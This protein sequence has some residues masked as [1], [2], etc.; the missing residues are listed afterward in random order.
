MAVSETFAD[1]EIQAYVS[2]YRLSRNGDWILD[3]I[4]YIRLTNQEGDSI[5]LSLD[6]ALQLKIKT[7]GHKEPLPLAKLLELRAW[8]LLE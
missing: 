4:Y 6:D 5:A 2:F 8:D 1:L 3:E 7:A